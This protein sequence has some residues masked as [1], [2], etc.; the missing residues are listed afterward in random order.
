ML[1]STYIHTPLPPSPL[2]RWEDL[3]VLPWLHAPTLKLAECRNR[4]VHKNVLMQKIDCTTRGM[5]PFR[6]RTTSCVGAGVCVATLRRCDAT[7]CNT[8]LGVVVLHENTTLTGALE[9]HADWQPS[10]NLQYANKNGGQRLRC[11]SLSQDTTSAAST[12]RAHVLRAAD[13][14]AA[15]S[16]VRVCEQAPCRQ[17]QCGS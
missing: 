15:D 6:V 4:H 5:Q 12:G 14:G 17:C 10:D 9:R 8:V 2:S 16:L 7:Q 3:P 13:H 11:D 1:F